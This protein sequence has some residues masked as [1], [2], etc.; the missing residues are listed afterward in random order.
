MI[1]AELG[2]VVINAQAAQANKPLLSAINQSSGGGVPI[3][4]PIST[5][6]ATGG[7][8]ARSSGLTAGATINLNSLS[9]SE[10]SNIISQTI[11]AMDFVLP[12]S[13][14]NTIQKRVE[15]IETNSS[16]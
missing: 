13:E 6:A 3:G 15:V 9:E 7:L 1:V 4:T 11:E 16:L 2:E 5:M 12:I 14:V 10:V 8:V